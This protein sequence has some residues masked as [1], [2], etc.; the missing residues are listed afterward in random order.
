MLSR[1]VEDYIRWIDEEIKFVKYNDSKLAKTPLETM[2]KGRIYVTVNNENKLKSITFY[3]ENGKRNRQID[4]SG[5]P[6]YID[7]KKRYVHTHLG[8]E[9]EEHGGTKN[10]TSDEWRLIRR[11]KHTWYNSPDR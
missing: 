8:Y 7:G 11:I 2:T 5:R 3:D 10:I 9:H 4:M 1:S 6:H